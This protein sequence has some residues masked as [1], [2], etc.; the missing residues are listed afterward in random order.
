[1]ISSWGGLIRK[2]GDTY[3]MFQ[4]RNREAFDFKYIEQHPELEKAILFQSRNREAFDF[5]CKTW[6]HH[7]VTIGEFQSRNREAFDFK[8][9][10]A[11]RV[12]RISEC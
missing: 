8:L 6:I 5:K 11:S 3:N 2:D 1:M 9:K 4:S 12:L 7:P 10:P